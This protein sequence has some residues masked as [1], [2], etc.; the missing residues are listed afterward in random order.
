MIFATKKHGRNKATQR[1]HRN[2]G[3]TKETHEKQSNDMRNLPDI[4]APIRRQK[5]FQDDASALRIH[6]KPPVASN[7]CIDS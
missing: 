6:A 4:G 1:K 7:I 5:M 2:T 3:K